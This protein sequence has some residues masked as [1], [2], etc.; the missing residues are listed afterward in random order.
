MTDPKPLDCCEAMRKAQENGTDCDGEW[1][2]VNWW[3][4]PEKR[5]GDVEALRFCP[6]CRM[7]IPNETGDSPKDA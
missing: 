2:A 6:W 4:G 7:P 1:A 3:A 5:G